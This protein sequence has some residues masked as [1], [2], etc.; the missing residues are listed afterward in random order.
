LRCKSSGYPGRRDS[1]SYLA[2]GSALVIF[3][4][5]ARSV[6]GQMPRAIA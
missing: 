2:R 5:A 4:L 3:L 1:M 6:D